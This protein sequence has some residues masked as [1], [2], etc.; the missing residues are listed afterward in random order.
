[1]VTPIKLYTQVLNL[2]HAGEV[3]GI[4]EKARTET[5]AIFSFA[6]GKALH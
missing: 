6:H 5:E 2:D 1:M 3:S 4:H